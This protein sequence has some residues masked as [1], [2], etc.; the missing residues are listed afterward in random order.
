MILS[1]GGVTYRLSM[2]KLCFVSF[3]EVVSLENLCEAWQEFIRGKRNK[4]DVL[5]F[6]RN[7]GDRITDLHLDLCHGVYQHGSY[8]HFSINDPKPRNIHK[9]T[10]RDRLVHHALHRKLYPYFAPSFIADSFSCQ[11]GK[12]LHRAID[13]F[14]LMAGRVSEN[15][16]K[17]CWVLKC[18]IR[19]FFA[20]VDHTVLLEVLRTSIP[21]QRLVDLL[22]RVI[23]SFEASPH[24]GIPLGNLTSQLFSNIVM[25]EFDRFVKDELCFK[26]Y[27][28]YADDFVFLSEDK[29]TLIDLLPK[30]QAYLIERLTLSLHPDKIILQTFASG[31]DFLGWIHFPHHRIPRTKTKKRML[32]R[33]EENPKRETLQSYLGLIKHGDAYHLS[34]DMENLY[35]LLSAGIIKDA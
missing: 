27:I 4:K 16:T 23:R 31:V 35:W 5:V 26:N 18:D 28:R 10:V 24:K 30:V 22:E 21:D 1:R 9:A 11:A 6:M 32:K 3:E 20:S 2:K 19:K 17:T 13:R 33:I 25:N 15:H 34:C 29:T 8:F 12:G 7:L 14:R